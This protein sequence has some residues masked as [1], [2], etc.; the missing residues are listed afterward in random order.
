MICSSMAATQ[1]C[2]PHVL[3]TGGEGEL[4]RHLVDELLVRGYSVSV[5]V[6][7]GGGGDTRVSVLEADLQRESDVERLC[8]LE[9]G[10]LINC[11]GVY[12]DDPRRC[13]AFSSAT[14]TTPEILRQTMEVNFFA[15]YKL[16]HAALHRMIGSNFGRI[17]N[18]SSGMGRFEEIADGAFA[19][20]LSKLSL[21]AFTLAFARAIPVAASTDVS[22]F[23]YCPG[24]MK[25][26]MGGQDAP[27]TAAANAIAIADL[28]ERPASVTNGR[29][30]RKFDELSWLTSHR[31]RL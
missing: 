10:V 20:R 6:R 7:S 23:A 14:A 2:K 15:P 9:Y 5:T 21:N 4:A 31:V 8:A 12:V 28:C 27:A 1:R 13:A 11:A 24:W 26:R 29:F 25:S 17:V 18:I 30:Y 19:Y 16:A 22:V 3:I